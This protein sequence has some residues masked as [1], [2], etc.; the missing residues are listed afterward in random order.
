MDDHGLDIP[1]QDAT[2]RSGP[3]DP[4][5]GRF[6]SDPAPIVQRAPKAPRKGRASVLAV[7]LVA[8]LATAIAFVVLVVVSVALSIFGI[9]PSW[10]AFAW[11]FVA[12]VFAVLMT[13]SLCR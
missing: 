10:A 13:R 7:L 4:A 8:L 9:G 6:A 1:D 11:P 2:P 5:Q 12:A 3:W